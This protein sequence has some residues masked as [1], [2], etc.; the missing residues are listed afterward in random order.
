MLS[1]QGTAGWDGFTLDMDFVV[2]N[3]TVAVVGDNGSGKTTLLRVVEIGRA[4]V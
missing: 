2:G 1:V 4:H 3:E